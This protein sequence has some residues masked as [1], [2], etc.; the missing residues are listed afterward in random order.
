MDK[1][2]VC[3]HTTQYPGVRGQAILTRTT[4]GMNR[5]DNVLRKSAGHKRTNIIGICLN[6]VPK[7]SES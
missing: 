1:Q 6:E 4:A 7:V 5:E 3:K 2:N